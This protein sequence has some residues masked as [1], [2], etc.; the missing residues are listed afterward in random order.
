MLRKL[1]ILDLPHWNP[2]A[3]NPGFEPEQ[4]MQSSQHFERSEPADI[5][6]M[7]QQSHQLFRP[8]QLS[9][10]SVNVAVQDHG[11][12]V[13][14]AT[15]TAPVKPPSMGIR[16][17]NTVGL[18]HFKQYYRNQRNEERTPTNWQE[19]VVPEERSALALQFFTQYRL[20]NPAQAEDEAT[21]ASLNRETGTFMAATDKESYVSMMK[22]QLIQMTMARQIQ[23]TSARK[24]LSRP[25]YDE[26]QY[27]PAP[28]LTNSPP[29]TNDRNFYDPSTVVTD[30]VTEVDAYDTLST[31]GNVGDTST[32]KRVLVCPEPRCGEKFKGSSDLKHVYSI[33]GWTMSLMHSQ[34]TSAKTPE[35]VQVRH[36][37]LQTW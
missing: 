27:A 35:A 14:N 6:R 3:H 26:L 18:H 2:Y 37:K 16:N 22:Q 4:Q 32:I 21:R 29:R 17:R 10:P 12:K 31:D 8:P 20:L 23:M 36:T 33:I 19:S 15:F 5:E 34:K 13:S 9:T 28:R 25:Y 7:S 11:N 30:T 24:E 1:I